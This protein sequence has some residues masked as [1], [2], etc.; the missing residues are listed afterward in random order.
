MSQHDFWHNFK[1]SLTAKHHV[2]INK[3]IIL[4]ILPKCVIRL[5]FPPI[6]AMEDTL[7]MIFRWFMETWQMNL[8]NKMRISQI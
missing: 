6:F 8:N 1:Y 3:I 7:E 5:R 4:H 2:N